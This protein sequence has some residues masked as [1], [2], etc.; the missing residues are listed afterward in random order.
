M[1]A[2]AF[3]P[4][5][6]VGALACAAG[7]AAGCAEY[8]EG[9]V[10]TELGGFETGTGTETAA[11]TPGVGGIDGD[12][13]LGP[14]HRAPGYVFDYVIDI[15]DGDYEQ[16]AIGRGVAEFNERTT[17]DPGDPEFIDVETYPTIA[18]L[19][20][21]R[22]ENKTIG[23]NRGA[24][25]GFSERVDMNI[26]DRRFN[27]HFI[28]PWCAGAGDDKTD[29]MVKV[30]DDAE[31]LEWGYFLTCKDDNNNALMGG[32]GGST[33]LIDVDD[34]DHEGEFHFWCINIEGSGRSII[35]IGT[36]PNWTDFAKVTGE[37]DV[38]LHLIRLHQDNIR[39]A[40]NNYP[41]WGVSSWH[42]RVHAHGYYSDLPWNSEHHFYLREEP[43]GD[44]T[45]EFMFCD[46]SGG[47]IIQKADRS[48]AL[49][50]SP[51]GPLRGNRTDPGTNRYYQIRGLTRT[52]RWAGKASSFFTQFSS[53]QNMDFESCVVVAV[54][55]DNCRRNWP[56]PNPYGEIKDDD[57]NFTVGA[58][59]WTHYG[60]KSA[61]AQPA[62]APYPGY[63]VG[64]IKMR[65]CV[66]YSARPTKDLVSFWAS[67]SVDVEDCGFFCDVPVMPA[68][69]TGGHYG[70]GSRA[71]ISIAPQGRGDQ[72]TAADLIGNFRWV[73][74]CQPQHI[75]LLTQAPYHVPEEQIVIPDMRIGTNRYQ[76]GPANQD[77]EFVQFTGEEYVPGYDPFQINVQ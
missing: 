18:V 26:A 22:T 21:R 45:Y 75:D 69:D 5:R 31:S 66:W 34:N 7:L 3:T 72:M 25:W 65:R 19:L 27:I 53:H 37:N 38:H 41:F 6:R 44:M 8:F 47:Q 24:N 20:P 39:F 43:Y 30:R 17:L 71:V 13:G 62:S 36:S 1:G 61:P 16:H 12:T 51:Q 68:H 11:S 74:N 15:S 57:F 4:I 9:D 10:P 2:R 54:D 77:I 55:T 35:D 64:T 73:G 50:N 67:P 32:G 48:A 42:T 76:L 40:S 33:L 23:I 28:G 14:D 63:L 58:S 60:N 46:R 49:G 70:P 29:A 59:S 52:G 56:P